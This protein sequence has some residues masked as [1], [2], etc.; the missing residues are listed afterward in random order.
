MFF[1]HSSWTRQVW[2]GGVGVLMYDGFDM[3]SFD[4]DMEWLLCIFGFYPDLIRRNLFDGN[5][6]CQDSRHFGYLTKCISLL[7]FPRGYRDMPN[8]TAL[9]FYTSTSKRVFYCSE[10]TIEWHTCM[11]SSLYRPYIVGICVNSSNKFCRF[12]LGISLNQ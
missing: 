11:G 4:R 12:Q 6:T 10:G 8:L 7:C 3:Q 9:S 1:L 5:G 2:D